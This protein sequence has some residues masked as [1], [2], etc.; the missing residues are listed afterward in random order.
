MIFEYRPFWLAV[1]LMMIKDLRRHARFFSN[2]L[3]GYYRFWARR[4][5][6]KYQL[7]LFN[8]YLAWRIMK[9]KICNYFSFQLRQA[10][11]FIDRIFQKK[12]R[13]VWSFSSKLTMIN[14]D[15]ILI[16]AKKDTKTRYDISP[17]WT[18]DNRQ[19]FIRYF[20]TLV[21]RLCNWFL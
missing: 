17:K 14:T 15:L 2:L 8:E 16:V 9:K 13:K 10:K 12:W 20:N 11:G 5:V 19:K 18:D 3:I 7:S 6:R 4:L 1:S 21:L